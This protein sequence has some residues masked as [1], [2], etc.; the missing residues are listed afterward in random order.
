M[1]GPS[2][3]LSMDLLR[4]A[5]AR[6][7]RS[8][9]PS[10]AGAALREAWTAAEEALQRLAG[11]GTLT[12]QA[13]LRELRGRDLL[14]LTE[15]HAIVDLGALAEK[16]GAGHA[17]TTPEIDAARQSF[18]SV[19]QVI[20]RRGGPRPQA[21]PATSAEPA[22]APVIDVPPTARRNILGRVLVGAAVVAVVG[23]ATWAAWAFQREPAEL[24]RGRASYAAGD[25]LTARNAFSAASGRHPE[26]AEPLIY[27]GRISREEGDLPSAREYLRRAIALEPANP[28]G[29][30][31][32]AGVLL[33]SG[34]PDVARPFYERAI[35]LAPEDR[36]ALGY[37]G[38]TLMQLGRPDLAQRFL[39]RA[40][41]GP[42]GGCVP[43]PVVAPAPGT[44]PAPQPR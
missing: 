9:N 44:A 6:L 32:L 20:E 28:L 21:A 15:A 17:P 38:C 33:A 42:W 25:R 14:S 30:R 29:H 2:A 13:L 26:L 11:S 12:G 34:R 36:T 1:T 37:M 39:S 40:G 10:E 31:E 41:Q 8:A 7:D 5:V 23:G 24:R 18:A 16:V 4:A 27:L 22:P 19:L 3:R 43:A 35:R